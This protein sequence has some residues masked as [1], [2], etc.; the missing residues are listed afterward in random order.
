M[1]TP[2]TLSGEKRAEILRLAELHGCR[3][4]RVFGSVANGE[5]RPDSDVDFLVD[6]ESGRAI[7]DLARFVGDLKGL[8]VSLPG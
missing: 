8:L 5:S 7:F 4:V 2:D 6:L 3:N 1:L